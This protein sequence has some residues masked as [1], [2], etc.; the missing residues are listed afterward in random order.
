MTSLSP[1]EI[2]GKLQKVMPKMPVRLGQIINLPGDVSLTTILVGDLEH[3]SVPTAKDIKKFADHSRTKL[4]VF[5]KKNDRA[6]FFPPILH[7]E[8]IKF[9]K[10][11]L[12]HLTLG[13][14]EKGIMPS[15]DDINEAVGMVREAIPKMK[16]GSKNN[17]VVFATPPVGTVNCEYDADDKEMAFWVESQEARDMGI[18]CGKQM[19]DDLA[20]AMKGVIPST[21][22]YWRN[23]CRE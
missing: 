16:D 22:I 18:V 2:V 19:R 23:T 3:G 17:V 14:I 7:L 10:G 9:R 6:F 20:K 21:R 4:K 1:N 5:T 12:L 13:D 11:H 15:I 8:L